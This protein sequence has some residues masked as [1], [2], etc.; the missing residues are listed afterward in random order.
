MEMSSFLFLSEITLLRLSVIL[1]YIE[2]SSGVWKC[3]NMIRGNQCDFSMYI[4]PFH[5]HY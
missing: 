5:C 1:E 2:Q 4:S 3:A